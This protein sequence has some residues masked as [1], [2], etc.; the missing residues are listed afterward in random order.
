VRCPNCSAECSDQAFK[1]G[2]CDYVFASDIKPAPPSME[3]VQMPLPPTPPS[4]APSSA[5]SWPPPPD[6]SSNQAWPPQDAYQ[7]PPPQN[8]IPN[9]VV[10]AVLS[11]VLAT[12]LSMFVCCCLP[13]G[14]PSGIAAIVFA[15]KVDKLI[16]IGDLQAA[17]EASKNAKIWCWVTTGIGALFGVLFL[18]SVF[19]NIAA[20]A[21]PDIFKTI[22][23]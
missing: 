2:F 19:F 14:L 6:Q 13:L 5:Q 21:S 8:T 16:E 17:E 15:L 23:G 12:G 7:D 11:T 20:M 18:L 4:A 3:T 22:G 1:C 9:Y 10:W